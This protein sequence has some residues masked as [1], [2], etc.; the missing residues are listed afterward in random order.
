MAFVA[1]LVRDFDDDGVPDAFAIARP[2][3]GA[4]PGQVAFYGGVGGDGSAALSARASFAPPPG[5][6]QGP[7]CAP[8]AR[9]AAIGRRTVLVELGSRCPPRVSSLPDRWLAVVAGGAA[10]RVRLA[11]TAIDPAGAP[12]LTVEGEASDRDGDGLDDV[13]LRVTL[14]PPDLA[15][16]ERGLGVD[17]GLATPDAPRLTATL[18][19]LDRQAG[20]SRDLAP[21]EAS[22]QS[23]AAM[24]ASRAKSTKDA[25]GVPLLVAQTRA[26]WRAVCADGGAPRLSGV[27]GTGAITCGSTRAL[28]EAGLAEVRSY[29]TTGD[30]LRAAL[31]LDRAERAPASRT[32]ARVAEARKWLEQLAPASGSGA[33][34]WLSAA[35]EVRSGHEPAWGALAFDADGGLLVRT[36]AGVVRV[37][38]EVADGSL[39]EVPAAEVPSWSTA[40]ASAD[41]ALRWIETYDACDGVAL[42]ASFAAGDDLRDVSLPVAPPLGDRCVGSRG[43]PVRAWPIAWGPAG[44]EAIADGEPVLV[45][46]ESG[47]A[48]L[49]S[50][51]L[52]SPVTRGA[53]RSPDGRILVVATSAGLLVRS[54]AGARL[55]RSPAPDAA[56]AEDRDCAV[57]NDASHVACV[58]RGKAWLGSWDT[59][60]PRSR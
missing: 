19:W 47:R 44:L 36:R 31:A 54:P 16:A 34:R 24:A 51:R 27:T 21:T 2:A 39:A 46:P 22:F 3:E 7:G 35:P 20:P 18:A 30:I 45:T 28:E 33:V 14:D 53:P 43:A 10:P 23:I 5:L 56:W 26:L 1:A 6:M 29:V 42:H 32:P 57:S 11:L 15:A 59:D 4:D 25:P 38:T 37:R 52:D 41:G 48:S 13:A 58:R 40:V 60:D 9:L 8:L 55:L 17:G 49:L 12:A 50:G